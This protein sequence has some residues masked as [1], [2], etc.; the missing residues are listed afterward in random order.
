VH[1]WPTLSAYSTAKFGV[2]GFCDAVRGELAQEGVGLT[3]VF[4]L[5]IDTPLVQAPDAPPILKQG[6]RLPPDAVVRKTLTGVARRR[7]RVFVPES[8][9]LVAALHALAPSVLDWYGRKFA[10]RAGSQS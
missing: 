2:A 1:G 10:P 7:A 8:V 6:R 9:R 3:T 5:L 4:P